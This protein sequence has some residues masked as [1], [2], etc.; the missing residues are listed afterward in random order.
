M[1][2]LDVLAQNLIFNLVILSFVLRT[3]FLDQMRFSEQR[4]ALLTIEIF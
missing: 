2:F 1:V 3:Y 4:W